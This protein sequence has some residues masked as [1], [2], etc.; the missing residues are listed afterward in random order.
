MEIEK[1]KEAEKLRKKI[2]ELNYQ[3]DVVV[4]QEFSQIRFGG[5]Y[6]VSIPVSISK[7]FFD[8]MKH[9]IIADLKNQLEPLTNQFE[10]L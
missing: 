1:Y 6:N 3:L 10:K 4:K 9:E 8:K 5:N 7:D 2:D